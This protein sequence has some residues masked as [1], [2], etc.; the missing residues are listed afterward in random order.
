MLLRRLDRLDPIIGTQRG[1][2]IRHIL[3]EVRVVETPVFE[4]GYSL[5]NGLFA[6]T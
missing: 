3:V 6:D 2:R 1:L 5:R 4:G